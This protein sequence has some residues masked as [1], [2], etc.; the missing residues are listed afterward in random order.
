MR[1]VESVSYQP[2]FIAIR[3]G[4]AL[5][6]PIVMVGALAELLRFPPSDTLRRFLAAHFGPKLDT[7]CDTLL[8]G[9][10]GIASL[11]ALFGFAHVL[12]DLHNERQGQRSV[13]P[14]VS[15]MIVL[16][17]FFIL[18]SPGDSASLRSALALDSGLLMALV[19]ASLSGSLF[20]A[21]SK[22][23]ALQMPFRT[24]N[25]DP[26]IGDVFRVMPAGM[27]TLLLFA[28]LKS[29]MHWT[30]SL[31][32]IETIRTQLVV[33]FIS[34]YPDTLSFAL[35]HVIVTQ[36]LWLFGL[37]GPN[38]LHLLRETLLLP[39][40]QANMAA[41]MHGETPLF[42]VT[43][44]FFDA[45]VRM[46]GSGSTLC[47]IFA[48][49]LASRSAHGRRFA[50]LMLPLALFNINEPL[51]FGLPLIFSPI[52]AVPFIL[53][54][55]L[56]ALIAYLAI[57]TGWMPPTSHVINWTTPVL[58]S[59]YATTGSLSG[60]LVQAIGLVVCTLCYLPF[61]RLERTLTA[62][63][64]REV[65]T[66][67][68]HT[69]ESPEKGLK[70]KRYLD[71]PGEEGRMAVALGTDL[72]EALKRE[73]QLFLEFQP[74]V[75]TD[76]GRVFGTEALLRWNH[77][78]FGRVAP[79]ITVTLAEDVGCTDQ[80]GLL[81]LRLACRQRAAWR[82]AIPE[83]VVMS[84]N[85]VPQQLRDRHFDRAVMDI[86]AAEKLP[87][88]M[89]E[90]EI[91]E[92]TMLLPE[93]HTIDSLKRLRDAGVKIALDDFGMGHTSLHYLRE[94]PLDT[95]KIDRSLATLEQGNGVNT[96]I[97][98]S[99]S[100]LSR[101]LNL[102]TIVEGV[103]DAAQLQRL[104]ALGL[105]RFQGYFFSR[106]LPADACLDFIRSESADVPR[107]PIQPPDTL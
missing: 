47:L 106:P 50:L 83:E 86:L 11:I 39:A 87:P 63:R 32:L 59:G 49:L 10:L 62:K 5:S 2:Y 101:N 98:R 45:F 75:D 71:L 96:H 12:T 30:E 94:L 97:V 107:Q 28:T 81:T 34:N 25:T 26:L 99:L 51:L 95:V 102:T 82:P 85:L 35:G 104:M 6:L 90:L 27:L 91:T 37:H 40:S 55:I 74:Q 56:H 53:T 44:G 29:L 43:S 36:V 18:I 54:P 60:T 79:P 77:P 31:S 20:L 52:Y 84:V 72:R 78:L 68:L 89:L 100:E 48:L 58:F 64:S 9:T 103:E 80:L 41:V 23:R 69:A 42:T 22:L 46:G 15:V 14:T 66:V 8:S 4:L 19:I 67:L 38:I 61:V 24:L 76:T 88:S 33:H 17:C 16:A 21:L 13:E 73:D 70:S 92:A 65:L 1:A 57:A 93:I 7:F 105:N 3:R